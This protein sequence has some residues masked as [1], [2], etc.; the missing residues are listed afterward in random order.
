MTIVCSLLIVL[1]R[2]M[3][4]LLY[5]KEFYDAWQYVP[6]LL[7]AIVFG[8]LSGYIG[9]I[10]AAVK[11]TVIFAKTSIIGAITNVIINI[12]M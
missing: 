12:I 5:A 11:D 10:F 3:A 4:R 6:F 7:I 9:G 2:V 1:T 8:A